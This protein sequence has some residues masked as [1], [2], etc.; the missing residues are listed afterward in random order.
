MAKPAPKDARLL[1]QALAP[2]ISVHKLRRLSARPA[3]DLRAALLV[4][5]PPSDVL[6]LL[7]ALSAVLRPLPRDMIREAAD[8]AALLMLEMGRLPQ[9]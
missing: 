4:D 3:A 6:A 7:D 8:I 5:Q 1:R 9:E 2:Y